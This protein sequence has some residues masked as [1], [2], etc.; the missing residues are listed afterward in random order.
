[1]RRKGGWGLITTLHRD[2]VTAIRL[3]EEDYLTETLCVKLV[4]RETGAKDL[5]TGLCYEIPTTSNEEIS[6][7][8]ALLRK[9][10]NVATLILGDFNHGDIDWTIGEVW[11]KGGNSLI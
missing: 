4:G 6:K 7:M 10:S 8:H 11:L 2:T 3:E 5:L 9:Y 1:V